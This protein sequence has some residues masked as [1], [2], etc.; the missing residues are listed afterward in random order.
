MCQIEIHS[1]I[2]LNNKNYTLSPKQQLSLSIITN[3]STDNSSKPPLYMVTKGTTGTRKSYL[4]SCIRNAL[5]N[6]APRVNPLLLLAPIGITTFNI[7][8][9]TI[10]STLKI[11]IRD[12]QPLQGQTLATFQEDVQN[13]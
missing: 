10:H 6:H 3:H 11:V 2:N 9:T 7:Q 13:I 5:Q 1:P 12:V 8:A 4:M